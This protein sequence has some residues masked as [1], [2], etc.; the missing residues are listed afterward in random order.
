VGGLQ[1]RLASEE[2]VV[3][4]LEVDLV[5]ANPLRAGPAGADGQRLLAW[6]PAT[7]RPG[8]TGPCGR[9]LAI[10][11]IPTTPAAAWSWS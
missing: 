1:A 4:P 9:Q 11:R 7:T 10:M 5:S 6:D 2:N 3:A 8:P